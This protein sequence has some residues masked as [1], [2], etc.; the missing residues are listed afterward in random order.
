VGR[1]WHLVPLS[2]SLVVLAVTASAQ[3]SGRSQVG[4]RSH[5]TASLRV[6]SGCVER[7][8]VARAPDLLLDAGELAAVAARSPTD[9]WAVGGTVVEHW[10]GAVWKV[11]APPIVGGLSDVA[12]VSKSDVW[13]V[14]SYGEPDKP[15]IAHWNGHSWT[16]IEAPRGVHSSLSGVAAL[17]AHDVWAVGGGGTAENPALTLHWNGTRWT[18]ISI[19]ELNATSVGLADVVAISPRDVWAV[20]SYSEGPVAMHWDGRRWQSFPEPNAAGVDGYS[21]F[22]A[23]TAVS[24][25]DVWAVGYTQIGNSING[26]LVYR[27]NGRE[28]RLFR[29]KGSSPQSG[30]YGVVA[31]SAHEI[32]TVGWADPIVSGSGAWI[33]RWNAKSWR[34]LGPMPERV[35]TDIATDKGTHMWAVG[36]TGNPTEEKD[37]PG[38]PRPIILRYGC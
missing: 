25:R 32:W 28:W 29:G 21:G 11:V 2:C 27:W 23:V 3:G 1:R 19:Q 38:L 8:K 14:G 15:L 16:L 36:S 5:A 18:K 30:L 33:S 26:S 13:A 17:S 12:T 37:L 6:R 34:S 4:L 31:R 35:L 10:N 7:W 24:S 22:D 9:A 20:G